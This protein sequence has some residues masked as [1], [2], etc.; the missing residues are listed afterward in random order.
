[1]QKHFL[2]FLNLP[3][4]EKYAHASRI[5][6]PKCRRQE[7][8]TLLKNER[9]RSKLSNLSRS[10]C[11]DYLSSISKTHWVTCTIFVFYLR[12][13]P[14]KKIGSE[15]WNNAKTINNCLV[16]RQMWRTNKSIEKVSRMLFSRIEFT[17]FILLFFHL[18]FS[19]WIGI[20][21]TIQNTTNTTNPRIQ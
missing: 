10:S 5:R 21:V 13:T 14:P 9:T 17:I 12:Q 6:L 8:Q 19:R 15:T 1:M 7:A 3:K 2:P 11:K 20:F 4:L 16:R 18:Y